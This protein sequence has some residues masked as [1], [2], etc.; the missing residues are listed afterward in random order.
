LNFLSVRWIRYLLELGLQIIQYILYFTR[1][2][3]DVF[4]EFASSLDR[5]D[6][7]ISCG[8]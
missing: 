1:C 8:K 7:S 4:V 3:L 5:S 2:A 6:S